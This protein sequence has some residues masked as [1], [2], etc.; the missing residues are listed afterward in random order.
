MKILKINVIMGIA[1]FC[2]ILAGY[3]NVVYLKKFTFDEDKPLMHWNKMIL[4]G[5]V[6]YIPIKQGEQGFVK[7]LSERACSA[8]YY[9]IK[10]KL[11]EYPLLSWKWKVLKFPDLSAI[12]EEKDK[13][14]YAARIYVV[15]P[16]LSFSSSK[17]IEYVW[18]QDIP[19]GTIMKSP[20][21]DNVK[22]IVARNHKLT[23]DEWITESRNVYEDYVKAFGGK[24]RMSVGA[25]AIMCDADNSQ[26]EAE[27][28][29]DDI[30]IGTPEGL[31]RRL[32]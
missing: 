22:L 11:E 32:E 12:L 5:E 31:K 14:D 21:A 13:D 1:I 19:I 18:A 30:A 16:F 7:A 26:T 8:L 10:F 3:S 25:V 27:S 28:F 15:F 24:P 6:N 23:D 2:L 29:F 20:V 17:F 9:R 4:N